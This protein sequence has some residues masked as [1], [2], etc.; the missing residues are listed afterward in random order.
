MR[1]SPGKRL[2]RHAAI[3]LD[4]QAGRRLVERGLGHRVEFIVFALSN[5]CDGLSIDASRSCGVW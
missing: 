3:H 4:A 1:S 2:G 5:A